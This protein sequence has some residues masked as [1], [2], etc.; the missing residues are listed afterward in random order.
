M[1]RF[2]GGEH[3]Y[4]ILYGRLLI[5]PHSPPEPGWVGIDGARIAEVEHGRPRERIDA[6]GEGCLICPGF[7]DAHLHLPQIDSI[8]C[9]GMELLDWLDRVI[10]PAE[11][12]WKDEK[13]ALRQIESAH[14]RLLRA[15][16][17]GYA[18]YLT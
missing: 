9:D 16:T 3:L 5:D 12:K 18:A 15:G 13:A 8:G 14:A 6:G 2:R 7:I 17:L 1:R 4:M 11:M 10:F